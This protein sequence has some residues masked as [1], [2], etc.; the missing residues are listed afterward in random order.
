[1]IQLNSESLQFF[2]ILAVNNVQDYDSFDK[3]FLFYPVF[4]L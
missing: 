1:M 3:N 4:V 2:D